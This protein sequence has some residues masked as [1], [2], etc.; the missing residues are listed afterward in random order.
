MLKLG[1]TFSMA[2]P[3]ENYR[4]YM[5]NA[6]EMIEVARSNLGNDFYSSACNRA[7]YAI[8]YA[9]SALLYSKGKSYGKHSAVI[10]AFR[11]YFIKTGEFDKK[12]S[13]AYEYIMSSRHTGDYELAD[14]L[15]KEQV[16]DV[17]KQA[18]A[19]VTEVEKWLLERDLL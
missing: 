14:P 7:Y 17:V 1:Y 5:E 3:R 9:A 8:F 18:K 12:W 6:R 2:D 4:L 19:F 13:D 10:A 11:Q 16:V 15:E